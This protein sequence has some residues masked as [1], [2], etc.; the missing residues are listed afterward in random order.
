MEDTRDI[1]CYFRAE[2]DRTYPA[3]NAPGITMPP[4]LLTGTMASGF[5]GN[6]NPTPQDPRAGMLPI[7]DPAAACTDLWDRNFM[8]PG[9][10]TSDFI[11]ADFI[12][13]PGTA[14][15]WDGRST[16]A[17]G[18][19]LIS[20]PSE[21]HAGHYVPQLTECVIEGTVSVI[22]GTAD[23]CSKLGIPSLVK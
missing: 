8:N 7:A 4:F 9:G 17:Q 11:P 16:D 18:K 6:H 14:G 13:P 19:P 2:L 15:G 21:H 12:T 10:I 3:P 20:G 5:D 22:P 1:R 23:I